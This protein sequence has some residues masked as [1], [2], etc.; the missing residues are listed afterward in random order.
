MGA[1]ELNKEAVK[2]KALP[3]TQSEVDMHRVMYEYKSMYENHMWRRWAK[4]YRDY[5]LDWSD[6]ENKVLWFQSNIKV[7]IIKQYV[8]ALWTSVY[9]NQIN[10]KTT[11]RNKDSYKKASSAHDYLSWAFTRSMSW[12]K[13]MDAVKECVIE[14]DWYVKVW[15]HNNTEKHSFKKRIKD[16]KTQQIKTIEKS[17]ET[18]EKYPDLDYVS[19]FNI[20]YPIYAKSIQE[21]PVVIERNILHYKT[22]LKRYSHLKINK[23]RFKSA[24]Y[25]NWKQIFNYDFDK[26]KL[27]AFWDKAWMKKELDAYCEKSNISKITEDNFF[28][29]LM[30]N[31]LHI[32]YDGWFMEVLEYREDDQL[33][34]YVN[35]YEIYSGSNPLPDKKHPYEAILFNKIPWMSH[36][37]WIALS[38]SDIQDTADDMM[39]LAIDNQKFLVAPMFE[40]IKWWDIFSESDWVIEWSPFKTIEVNQKNAITRLDVWNPNLAWLSWG[41]EFLFQVWEMSEWINSYATWYQNKVERSATWVSALVQSFK[42]RLLP[43]VDSLNQALTWIA[44]KWLLYWIMYFDEDVEIQKFTDWK[45]YIKSITIEELMWEYSI[46]FNAQSLKTATRE[47]KRESLLNLLNAILPFAQMLKENNSTKFKADDFLKDIFDTYELNPEKY[48]TATTKEFI[49]DEVNTERTKMKITKKIQEW[50]IPTNKIHQ[51]SDAEIFADNASA[52][53]IANAAV[54][55]KE[56]TEDLEAT[57]WIDETTVPPISWNWPL[58]WLAWW[59]E[60]TKDLHKAFSPLWWI[61]WK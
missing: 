38:L 53:Q 44:K 27:S 28:D 12:P 59:Q 49:K 4:W 26:I 21:S 23:E 31:Y 3:F 61:Y 39:N 54:A 45:S 35:W 40:R 22:I 7:P 55:N 58:G 51:R 19:I 1:L 11:W 14:W 43:M 46:E 57:P 56:W 37:R 18:V 42:A 9:D 15:F 34:I 52:E 16:K 17:W 30:N 2:Y 6:R 13:L 29:I 24:R 20:F 41:I 48:F 47:L 60:K 32:N 50:V 8:D 10:F 33:S 36:G 5:L 25:S